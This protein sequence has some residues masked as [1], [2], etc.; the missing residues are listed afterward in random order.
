MNFPAMEAKAPDSSGRIAVINKNSNFFFFCS[1]EDKL[2]MSGCS[3]LAFVNR[4]VG[5]AVD[6][7][8][9]RVPVKTKTLM[10]VV[11]VKLKSMN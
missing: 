1:A 9:N 6:P 7:T 2:W 8:A 10:D 4:H 11:A 5:P 3:D